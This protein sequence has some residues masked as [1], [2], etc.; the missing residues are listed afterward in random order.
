MEVDIQIQEAQKLFMGH[1][2]SDTK[3]EV[4]SDITATLKKKKDLKR[5]K[6]PTSRNKKKNK[7]SPNLAKGNIKE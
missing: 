1:S 4:Y 7:L 2:K 6:I 3:R 5:R